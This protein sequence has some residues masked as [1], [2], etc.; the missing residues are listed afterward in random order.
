R[1]HMGAKLTGE[2]RTLV[3]ATIANER[4]ADGVMLSLMLLPFLFSIGNDEVSNG[5]MWVVVLFALAAVAFGAVLLLREQLFSLFDTF[6]GK[7]QWKS[8]DYTRNRIRLFLHGLSPLFSLK[9]FPIVLLWSV[10]VWLVELTVYIAVATSYDVELSL[11][12]AIIFLA[13]VNFSSLIP[14]APGGIGVIEAIASHILVAVGVTQDFEIAL[15]M[16]L[17]QH[18]IQ[19][20]VVGAPGAFVMFSWRSKLEEIEEDTQLEHE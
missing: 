13:A 18:V 4:L 1:A 5:L 16:V 2:K 8:T 14:A 7:L 11:A 6:H 17:S 19:Y 3:L 15:A 12:Q 9:R 20:I 10:L